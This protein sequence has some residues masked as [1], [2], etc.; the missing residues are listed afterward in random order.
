MERVVR[1]PALEV[2]CAGITEIQT[3]VRADG[4]R[5][6]HTR[7]KRNNMHYLALERYCSPAVAESQWVVVFDPASPC[8]RWI[9]SC[10]PCPTPPE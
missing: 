3:R 10:L 2:F 8:R 5:R 4:S 1:P 9:L 6:Q 7:S